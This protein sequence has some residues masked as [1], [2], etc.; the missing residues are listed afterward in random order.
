M[1]RL[2]IVSASPSDS[3]DLITGIL[4]DLNQTA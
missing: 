3:A 4:S 1:E 2:S